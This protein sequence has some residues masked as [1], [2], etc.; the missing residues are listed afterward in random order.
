MTT[1][2]LRSFRVAGLP[3]TAIALGL[4]LSSYANQDGTGIRT[5]PMTVASM[6]GVTE[7]TFNKYLN[8]LMAEGWLKRAMVE[9]GES[10]RLAMPI[11]QG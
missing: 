7:R 3:V 5:S 11:R 8:V 1:L 4:I 10:Y 2:W 9:G 6:L